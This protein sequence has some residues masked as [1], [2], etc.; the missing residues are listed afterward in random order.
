MASRLLVL[1]RK[2]KSKGK[3]IC[4]DICTNKIKRGEYIITYDVGEGEKDEGVTHPANSIRKAHILCLKK[5]LQDGL[6]VLKQFIN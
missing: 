5:N 6:K 2:V 4:C 3:G 1:S